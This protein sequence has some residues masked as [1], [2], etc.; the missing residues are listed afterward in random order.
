[1][2]G[3]VPKGGSFGG[4]GEVNG[5]A[6]PV[7]YYGHDAKHRIY[8]VSDLE[9]RTGHDELTSYRLCMPTSQ[10]TRWRSTAQAL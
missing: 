6:Q 9:C 7:A 10:S 4:Y 8:T 2:N 1:M 5:H 3:L